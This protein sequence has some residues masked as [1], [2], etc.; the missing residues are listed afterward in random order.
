MTTPTGQQPYQ[1]QPQVVYVQQTEKNGFGTTAFVLGIVSSVVGLVPILCYPALNLAKISTAVRAAPRV[2]DAT[3]DPRRLS[4][5]R[6]A[7]HGLRN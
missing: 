2:G 4:A 5:S 3:T 6:C 7:T 1:K